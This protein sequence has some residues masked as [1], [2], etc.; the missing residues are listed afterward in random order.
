MILGIYA[1]FVFIKGQLM[2][3]RVLL[4]V[5]ALTS[6]TWGLTGIF[7]RLLPPISPMLVASARLFI[8]LL[9]VLP[10]IILLKNRQHG[11]AIVYKQPRAYVLASLLVAYYLLATVAFQLAPVAEV[12][13]L[14]STPPL[15]V[16]ALRSIYGKKP[17]I[18][19]VAGALL[20]LA[21]MLVVMLPKITVSGQLSMQQVLGDIAAITAALMTALYAF[22]YKVLAEQGKAPEASGVALLT[23]AVGSVVLA[24]I[25]ACNAS[26]AD[27]EPID[28]RALYL[29]IGLGVLS[30]A[31]PTFGFALASKRL[32]AIITATISLFIPLF[33]GLFAFLILGE[34]LSLNFLLGSLLVIGGVI[35][36]IRQTSIPPLKT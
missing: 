30:T 4:L 29:F 27:F 25:F 1:M 7:I 19:E 15:F 17:A 3:D 22:A 9:I 11:L 8:A 5:A 20:A 31:I 6:L 23:F 16:L 10:I 26:P 2:S 21:G 28:L 32:P 12:A 36:I 35:L 14:L 33:A 13:L 18:R 24:A 34:S